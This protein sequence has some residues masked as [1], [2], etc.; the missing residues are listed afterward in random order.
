MISRR[1]FILGAIGF[2]T[3]FPFKN[4]LSSIKSER[5]LKIYNIH[6]EETL[7]IKYFSDNV[8][9]KEALSKIN[10]LLRCHYTNEVKDIDI[11]LIN[12][13]C[14][15]KDIFGE[16]KQINIISGY[17][18]YEY[19]NYLRK[20]SNGVSKN[21]YHLKGLAID[22]VIE[23]VDNS[24]ISEAA[25]SFYAGGVGKYSQFVHIDLGPVRYWRQ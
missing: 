22:F 9:D 14:D 23:G 6:T 17:R 25:K 18:S 15:I 11:R 13:L 24:R 21:S 5:V 1:D 19:N 3:L 10:Y 12:L 16:K 2:I 8:Y 4:A 7:D 20:K